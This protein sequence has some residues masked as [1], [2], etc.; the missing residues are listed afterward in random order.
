MSKGRN[1]RKQ[2]KNNK[3]MNTKQSLSQYRE[4]VKEAMKQNKLVP[5]MAAR[6]IVNEYEQDVKWGF[7]FRNSPRMAM[8]IIWAKML[9]GVE[10]IQFHP[11]GENFPMPEN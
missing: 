11:I 4:Q 10:P 3:T 2:A 7:L 1:A 8:G 6:S 9:K 5:E